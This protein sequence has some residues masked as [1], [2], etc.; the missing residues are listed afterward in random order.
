[1]AEVQCYPIWILNE[2]GFFDSTGDPF[3]ENELKLSNKL[4]RKLENW[5][6]WYDKGYDSEYPP[7]S[8][9]FSEEESL[10]FESGGVE[11][12]MKLKEELGDGFE[13]QYA[14]I[15]KDKIYTEIEDY[16]KDFP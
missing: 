2:E 10:E 9:E 6:K 16:L 11:I 15:L 14:S 1:M 4:K 8:I 12:W 5:R 7:D 3:K 13:I